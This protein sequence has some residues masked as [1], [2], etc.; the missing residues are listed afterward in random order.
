MLSKITHLG[1][2]AAGWLIVMEKFPKG[3]LL[4]A[5]S[6]TTDARAAV[7]SPN[8][9]EFMRGHAARVGTSLKNDGVDE[10]CSVLGD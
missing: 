4:G 2:S 1:G 10:R 8:K 7:E 5:P 9:G 6:G 3:E